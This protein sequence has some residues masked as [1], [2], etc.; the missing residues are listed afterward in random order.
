MVALANL[1][2]SLKILDF[3]KTSLSKCLNLLF[4]VDSCGYFTLIYI[5]FIP[6]VLTAVSL[7][8]LFLVVG[9]RFTVPHHCIQNSCIGSACF[10]FL[11]F[12]YL[13]FNLSLHIGFLLRIQISLLISRLSIFRSRPFS[14]P[15]REKLFFCGL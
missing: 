1:F 10:L 11:F 7:N 6:Q 3:F 14:M 13:F 2:M 15:H 12:D 5:G 9:K 4:L 8:L